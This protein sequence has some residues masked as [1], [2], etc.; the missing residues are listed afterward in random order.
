MPQEKNRREERRLVRKMLYWLKGSRRYYVLALIGVTMA[1]FFGYVMPL[2]LSVTVDSVIGTEPFALPEKLVQLIEQNGW[3]EIWRE[4][5]WISAVGV[6]VSALLGGVFTYLRGRCTSLASEGVAQRLRNALYRHLHTLSYDY[7]VKAETGDLIQRCSSDVDT[8]RQ[9]LSSQLMEVARGILMTAI[10]LA[11]LIPINGKLT[12]ISLMMVVPMLIFSWVYFRKVQ[13][14]FRKADE[15][16]GVMSTV[17]Q[18]NLTGMRVVRAFGQQAEEIK[19][20]DEKNIVNRDLYD[21]LMVLMGL[22]WG[23]SDYMGFLQIGITMTAGAI[24]AVH[25]EITLGEL[26]VFTYYSSI[27]LWPIRQ[28]G[29]I[30]ADFGKTMVSYERLEDILSQPSEPEDG[31]EDEQAVHG[32]LVFDHVTF[33]YDPNRPILRDVSFTLPA[34][35]TLAILGGTGSG[36]S[37]LVHLL[38]RLYDCD[39]GS[40]TLGGRDIKEMNRRWLRGR[41]GLVLQEPFL[42]SKSIAE[43]IALTRPDASQAE[44]EQAAKTAALHENIEEFRDGYET[45][46][47][48]RGVTLSGGQ[49][50]RVAIARMLMQ[51]APIMIFDDSLSAV[52][53][54]TDNQIREALRKARKN[55]TT[56]IISHRVSTLSQ[57]DLILVM[58]SGRI[59]EQGTHRELLENGGMYSRIWN[60]QQSGADG[61]R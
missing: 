34:G 7:H 8:I 56:I 9:F 51:N 52:D 57:A 40:I 19:K 46:V 26:M 13:E 28:M 29:R 4:N 25:G 2:I 21:W 12:A 18:E 35:K 24:M 43:N 32:D 17:L 33:G 53:T 55:S 49:K 42:F 20:F 60:I 6:V 38:Q 36:K 48:E 58:E 11:I 31:I 50:Q 47:G 44:I 61:G 15:A 59:I 5:L 54:Q 10:G 1:S 16:E 22:F 30:L 37:T 45:Q 41:V 27:M 14:R 23:L 39:G 3:R